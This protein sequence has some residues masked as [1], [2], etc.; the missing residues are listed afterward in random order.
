MLSQFWEVGSEPR[1]NKWDEFIMKRFFFSFLFLGYLWQSCNVL[2]KKM[3]RCICN[4]KPPWIGE[5]K[6][7][8]WWCV[9]WVYAEEAFILPAFVAKPKQSGEDWSGVKTLYQPVRYWK[10]VSLCGKEVVGRVKVDR[11]I[12]IKQQVQVLQQIKSINRDL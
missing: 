8:W 2:L 9:W 6:G 1:L 7:R 12:N 5:G 11:V 4:V 3:I 10:D